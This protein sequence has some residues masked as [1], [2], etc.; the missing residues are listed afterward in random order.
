MMFLK[1]FK[2]ENIR[3]LSVSLGALALS[4]FICGIIIAVIGFNPFEA[5]YMMLEGAFGSIR[6]V[7]NTLANSIPLIFTGLAVAVASKAGLLNIG[8]EGQ[9]YIG[10][11]CGTLIALYLPVSNS[12]VMVVAILLASMIGGTVWGGI[13]GILKAKFKTNE[14]LVAI[15]LNYIA[16]LFTSYLVI[17]PLREPGAT[18][19]QTA[20]IP[21]AARLWKIVPRTQ[22][23]TALLMALV[24]VVLVWFLYERTVL[25]FKLRAVGDNANASRANGITPGRYVFYAM[26]LSGAIAS[27]AGTTEVIG[28]YYRFRESFSTDLGFT[29]IA[30]AV[31]ARDNPFAIILTAILFGGL[32]TGALHM[33]RMTGISGNMSN[34]IQSIIILIVAAP[35]MI[36]M[37]FPG[38]EDSLER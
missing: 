21:E 19:N 5:Y 23:T 11:M 9:L 14:V 6:E 35:R 33:G 25:G 38:K 30:V 8:A 31:L 26:M 12:I 37:L 28:K 1:P 18:V 3:S 10:A 7:A 16:M 15:M 32:N 20:M 13:P 2:S 34:V 17:H 4:L 29:G 22:L 27:L 24:A 36:K